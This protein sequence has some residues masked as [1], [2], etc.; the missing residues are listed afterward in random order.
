M[1][2]DFG[3]R[4]G[5]WRIWAEQN[6]IYVAM[7]STAGEFKTS[8]HSSGKYRHAFTAAAERKYVR[9]GQDRAIFK[10]REPPWTEQGLRCLLEVVAPTDELTVPNGEPDPAEKAKT[11]LI[12]PAPAGHAAVISVVATRPEVAVSRHP[13]PADGPSENLARWRLPNGCDVWIVGSHQELDDAFWDLV[14]DA[15]TQIAEVLSSAAP[16]SGVRMRLAVMT[17]ARDLGVGRYID[18]SAEA[19]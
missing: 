9:P 11:V 16:V 6:D 13:T 7:R 12:H 14:R 4:S 8:L 1:G 18:L 2:T 5:T 15:R 3:P 19:G 17:H 10:W